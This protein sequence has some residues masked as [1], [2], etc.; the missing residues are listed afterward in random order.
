VISVDEKPNIQALER[1]QGYA[2]SSDRK[3]VCA[4]Q[5]AYKRHGTLNLFAAL[6]VAT[7]FIHGQA[8]HIG[9]KTK[10]GLVRFLEDVLAELPEAS[11]YRVILDNYSIHKRHEAWRQTPPTFIFIT[12]QLRPVG[13]IWSR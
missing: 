10:K 7:G 12:R 3:R 1:Q 11:E 5:S 4:M 13:W 8:T 6:E 9:E 2:V